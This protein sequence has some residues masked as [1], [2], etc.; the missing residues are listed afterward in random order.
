MSVFIKE[1]EDGLLALVET[2]PEIIMISMNTVLIDDVEIRVAQF[3]E[4][5]H[6]RTSMWWVLD[7]I[8]MTLLCDMELYDDNVIQFFV[9]ND[10]EDDVQS[11]RFFHDDIHIIY[12]QSISNTEGT[13]HLNSNGNTYSGSNTFNDGRLCLGDPYS[14]FDLSVVDSLCNLDANRDLSWF[15]NPMRFLTKEGKDIIEVWPVSNNP[16]TFVIPNQILSCFQR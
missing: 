7:K 6:G 14:P 10:R 15:G 12:L 2:K 5:K 4:K 3:I 9:D 16:Q 13:Y 1:S 11:H 8:S